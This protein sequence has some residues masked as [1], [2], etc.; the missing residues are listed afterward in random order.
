LGSTRSTPKFAKADELKIATA[1]A[2]AK[3]LNTN[4]SLLHRRPMF[5][6]IGDASWILGVEMM[7]VSAVCCGASL[8]Y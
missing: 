7:L 6:C 4:I 1:C 5:H 2:R 8:V 3:A